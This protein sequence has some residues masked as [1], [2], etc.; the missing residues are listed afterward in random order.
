MH[1]PVLLPILALLVPSQHARGQSLTF[2]FKIP[3]EA[4]GQRRMR[5][6]PQPQGSPHQSPLS[7][8]ASDETTDPISRA[9]LA[10][11]ALQIW[12]NG[13]TGLW[14]TSG[15]WNSANVMT[16]V[17]NLAKHDSENDRLVDLAKRIFANTIV[18]APAKNPQP[19]VENGKRSNAEV[20]AELEAEPEEE[21]I[22]E[23]AWGGEEVEEEPWKRD[24]KKR[25]KKRNA[26]ILLKPEPK[27]SGYNK[28][29]GID[30]E[31][32]S[33]YPVGWETNEYVDVKKLPINQ[34]GRLA[35]VDTP[36]PEDWLDGFYDD[37]LWWALA[38]IGAYDVT[39]TQ[40]YLQL[41][42]GL[43]AAV[44][45][46]WP[47]R[48][49]GGGIFW[50]WE[51]TYMNAIAN[52]LFLSTAAHL[53]NRA[54]NKDFYVDWARRELDW[55]VNSGMINERGTINDGLTE[56]CQNN[57][58]TTWSYNQGV[59]LG[60]LVELSR[61][62]PSAASSYVSLATRTAKAAIDELSDENGVL[63]D[64]CGP[65][66]GGDASQFKGIFA[67]NLM[68]LHAEAPDDMFAQFIRIN[69]DSI[70]AN[71]RDDGDRLSINWAGPYVPVANATTHGSAMDALVAALTV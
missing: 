31:V 52:E 12:Y 40:E 36:N 59:I 7:L 33:I 9:E 16:M 71:D 43:F 1:I 55:F 29:H 56:D 50:S 69:A 67:R 35:A 39:G 4:H 61:A 23:M 26:T 24:S 27:I 18:Q 60:G 28:S 2:P 13:G 17:T 19:G 5:L 66:C 62:D 53:A 70:W 22:E 8:V 3:D 11:S 30:G 63:H 46:S 21:E 47:T 10:F 15:W 49:G 14:D 25:K 58:Q 34:P 68:L 6:I 65:Y 20:L 48:C 38:W 64:R 51:E 57:N 42:E 44:T 32:Y 37:D 54:D 41:A 45:K